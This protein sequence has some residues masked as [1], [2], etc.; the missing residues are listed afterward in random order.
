MIKKFDA[1]T[2]PLQGSNLIEASAGTGKTYS[3]AILML[4]LLL[5][6]HIE[7]KEVLMVTFTKAA[8][9]ELEERIRL[10][11]RLAFKAAKG[12]AI[13]EPLI[14]LL[15]QKSIANEG[16]EAVAGRLKL[17]VLL[18]D[19]TAV[20]TIH[21]FC[22]QTLNEFAFE[23]GQLFD[24]ETLKEPR[25][26]IL[27]E[28]DKF[29][30]E[31]VTTVRLDLLKLL[32]S[33]A[34]SRDWISRVIEGHFSGKSYIHY[35]LNLTYTFSSAEQD[36]KWE[37]V[38]H[39]VAETD[40]CRQ[41]LHTYFSEHA[42]RLRTVTDGNTNARKALLHLLEN[43]DGFIKIMLSK[44]TAQYIQNLYPDLL[45]ACDEIEAFEG[46]I[47]LIAQGVISHLYC[48]AIQLSEANINDYKLRNSLLSFDDMITNLHHAAMRD[49]RGKLKNHLRRKYKAVFI[50]EFQDTD[51]LQYEMF[52]SFFA[53]ETVLF[54]IGDPK[55]SIYAFRKADINTYLKAA[56]KVENQ[57]GMNT[58][59][60]SSPELVAAMNLFFQPEPEFDTFSF[61]AAAQAITYIPVGAPDGLDDM[62]LYRGANKLVP[63]NFYEVAD[64]NAATDLAA[65]AILDLLSDP[66]IELRK[67]GMLRTVTPSMI[68]VLVR[69]GYQGAMIKNALG[70]R[71]I[72][73]VTIDDTKVLQ[74]DEAISIL[75]L[76]NAFEDGSRSAINKALLVPFTGLDRVAL[77][78]LDQ[79]ALQEQFKS[80]G[81]IWTQ[82]GIFVTL[83]RF[84]L[85]YGVKNRLLN[86]R[87]NSGERVMTNLVQLTEV[88][89]K[90]QTSK[91]LV[92]IELINWLR[93]AIEGM[94]VDG[95]EYEQRVE[96]D[97]EAVKIITI[98]KSKGLEYPIV[99]APF[100]DLNI[101]DKREFCSFRDVDREEY[102]F[103]HKYQLSTDQQAA[104]D[105]QQ[106]QEN[107]RL[108]YVAITRA[109]FHCC[110][111]KNNSNRT[112]NSSLTPFYKALKGKEKLADL[113]K[114]SDAAQIPP[115]RNYNRIAPWQPLGQKVAQ[116]FKLLD[117][118]WHKI[119]YSYLAKRHA[120]V[121]RPDQQTPTD[122]Y[123]LFVFKQMP[124]GS[125]IGNM[126]HY[127]FE[128]IDFT[129]DKNWGAVVTT[130]LQRFMP[131][132]VERFLSQFL[133]LIEQTTGALIMIGDRQI[134]LGTLKREKKISEFEFDYPVGRFSSLQLDGISTE[135]T[136]IFTNEHLE[137]S[138]IM[139]GKVDLFFEDN[140]RYYILDWKSNFLGDHIENYQTAE[141]QNAMNDNN[142]HLQYMIYA[143]ALKKYLELRIAGFDYESQFGGIIYLFIRGLRIG[144][145]SGVYTYRPSLKEITD[146]A[147]ILEGEAA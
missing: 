41:S 53:E 63:M 44:R 9:A 115:H 134:S 36:V 25:L 48:M 90:I 15:V 73:A 65:D 4:R 116:D 111:I 85:D 80:Y 62:G 122:S 2:V 95:D 29:W 68:G 75:Y 102:L 23:T 21:S 31:R 32:M 136:L 126:L 124:R 119:S 37:E 99:M 55:Q 1:K 27:E 43:P 67:K 66:S 93:K 10:F 76:L 39:L 121:L 6:Q 120:F 5:E 60:R 131:S 145:Q 112:T 146:L 3:I 109:A 11:I 135:Q 61:G 74:S 77:L 139:N 50:D 19:E 87:E 104:F 79:D 7:I 72:P 78:N 26:L 144:E 18:L 82:E 108:L 128:T 28:V 137:L 133:R 12:E 69:A 54:Y 89:H 96:S 113:I 98:H 147:E 138:G 143:L 51:K 70:K 56:E 142:Y 103:A 86:D 57:Y 117:M 88:L 14:T 35:N 118:S 92:N 40:R 20:M 94:N 16:Q 8:V 49:D 106:E 91:Q 34:F 127:I 47:R 17:A 59:Y 58:N 71:G 42:D 105:Q 52:E 81:Q 83:S 123:D 24:C 140:G 84:M 141:L 30:R 38:A 129:N 13:N 101:G 64:Q 107:R 22:Q 132:L 114:F 45:A 33:E 100:L 130:A 46:Q 97:E 125:V 110:I